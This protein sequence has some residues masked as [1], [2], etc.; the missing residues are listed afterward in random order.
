MEIPDEFLT[1][2][3]NFLNDPNREQ[4][5][6]GTDRSGF[7]R[8]DSLASHRNPEHTEQPSAEKRTQHTD[9]DVSN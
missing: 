5:H 3:L 4:Q 9:Y 7:H 8:T 2:L 6:D 1:V